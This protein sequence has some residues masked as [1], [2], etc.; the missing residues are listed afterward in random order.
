MRM[1]RSEMCMLLCHIR[2][3]L[4]CYK[5]LKLLSQSILLVLDFRTSTINLNL[6]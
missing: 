2:L 3:Y 4:E 6:L 5:M 1:Q